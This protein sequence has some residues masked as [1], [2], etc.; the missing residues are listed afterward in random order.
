MVIIN[1]NI[2]FGNSRDFVMIPKTSCMQVLLRNQICDI[3]Y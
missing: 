2:F 3:G 1:E